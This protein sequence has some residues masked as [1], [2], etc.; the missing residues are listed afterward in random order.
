MGGEAT[1]IYLVQTER[2]RV[3]KQEP[4][5]WCCHSRDFDMKLPAATTWYPLCTLASTAMC[6]LLGE[7]GKK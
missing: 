7:D 2:S 5:S 4:F 6:T 3:E 1:Q